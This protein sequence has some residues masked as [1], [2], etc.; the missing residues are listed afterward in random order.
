MM[1]LASQNR[2]ACHFFNEAP[3]KFFYFQKLQSYSLTH[4]LNKKSILP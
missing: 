3:K 2:V 1:V 4:W